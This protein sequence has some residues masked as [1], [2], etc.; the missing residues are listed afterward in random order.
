MFSATACACTVT[1]WLRLLPARQGR[2]CQFGLLRLAHHPLVRRDLRSLMS[3][4]APW[5]GWVARRC[6]LRVVNDRPS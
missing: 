1:D 2:Q 5:F 3:S 4:H 6:P